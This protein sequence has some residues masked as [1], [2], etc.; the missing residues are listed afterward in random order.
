MHSSPIDENKISLLKDLS[1][2]KVWSLLVSVFGD[3]AA[4][5][6]QSLSSAFLNELFTNIGIKSE[7]LRVALHRLRKDGWIEVEKQGRTSLYRLTDFGRIETESAF[8]LVYGSQNRL[9][10]DWYILVLMDQTQKPPA[11]SYELAPRTFLC[12]HLPD[13]IDSDILSIKIELD[14]LPPWVAAKISS[15]DSISIA[16]E[17]L[18]F[19]KHNN[20]VDECDTLSIRSLILHQWRRIA[21]RETTWMNI[22]LQPD[23]LFSQCHT[24]AHAALNHLPRNNEDLKSLQK[25][26]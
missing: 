11:N 7:A 9:T 4:N 19:L 20:K 26:T 5:K 3:L 16:E 23:G 15:P 1:K 17:L 10:N 18:L 21:L 8:D 13:P 12:K 25:V 6:D 22:S 14:T 2:I 24:L